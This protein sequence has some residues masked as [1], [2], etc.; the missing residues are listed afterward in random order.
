M[1]VDDSEGEG[2]DY[3]IDKCAL[4]SSCVHLPDNSNSP[5]P[6][7]LSW[8]ISHQKK[9]KVATVAPFELLKRNYERMKR[10]RSLPLPSG[11]GESWTIHPLVIYL[12]GGRRLSSQMACVTLWEA[13]KVRTFY[14]CT[15]TE[16]RGVAFSAPRFPI[17]VVERDYEA[18]VR[19]H[20]VSPSRKS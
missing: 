12:S 18:H 13:V 8:V 6:R 15:P 5:D 10:R 1:E 11:S 4:T 14:E 16:R 20:S 19:R 7:L 3:Y 2:L 17:E 9:D